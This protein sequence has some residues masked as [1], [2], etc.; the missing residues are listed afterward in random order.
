MRK[1][2]PGISFVV[3]FYDGFQRATRFWT[4]FANVP[5]NFLF[6]EQLQIAVFMSR[7]L[8]VSWIDFLLE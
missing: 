6:S 3:F 4:I 1:E 8:S 5:H 2:V 7:V